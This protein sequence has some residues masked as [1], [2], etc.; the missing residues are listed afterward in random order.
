MD[1]TRQ[2]SSVS[3]SPRLMRAVRYLVGKA[4][5]IALTI[6]AGVFITVLLANQP[7][8]GGLG[9]AT[10]PFEES[11]EAQI[12]RVVRIQL[13]SGGLFWPTTAPSDAEVEALTEELREE[14]G[15]NLPRLPRYLLWTLKA[16]TFDWG[17]LDV[18]RG[19]ATTAL[20]VILEF[21]PNT[22]L[23]IGAAY[24]LVFVLGLPISLYLARNYG[25][26]VDRVFSVLAPVSAVPSWVFAILLI[27]IF[28]FQL[29]WLPFGGKYDFQTPSD[30]LAHALVVAKHMIL[31]VAAI[32]LSLI[33]Q[34]VYTWRTFFIIY[35]EE[36][37]VELARAKGLSSSVLERRYI[38][39]P[40]LPYVVTS[41]LTTLISFWQLSMVQEYVFDW[42]GL[43][44]LYIHEA[45]PNFWGESMDPGELIIVVAIVVIFAYLLG[46]MVF[47]LDFIYVLIDPRILLL[48]ANNARAMRAKT[49]RPGWLNRLKAGRQ[50]GGMEK[51]GRLHTSPRPHRV[52]WRTAVRDLKSTWLE[53]LQRARALSHELRRYP[54]AM[55]GLAVILILLAGSIY[56]VMALP[57]AEIGEDY[58]Q[59]RL[60]GRN[61]APRTAKPAWVNAFSATPLLSALI[62][63]EKSDGTQ[64]S[65]QT[66][67]NGWIQKT[68]AFTFDYAYREI[69]SEVFLYFDSY[70]DE[71][72][73]FVSMVWTYPDGRTLDLRGTA[74]NGGSSYDFE[75]NIRTNQLLNE[76]PAWKDW[77]VSTGQYR[78]PA[79][80]LLF[81][82]PGSSQPVPQRGKY[83][84]TLT[85][86]LF[87]ESSD[88]QPQLV[89]LGQVYGLAGTDHARR[90]LV[91]PLFWG[92]P[93]ALLIG[94]LGTLI[95]TLVAMLLPAIGVWFG[96]WADHI[97]QRLTEINMVL[98]S[99]SVAVLV[100][101]VFSWNIWIILGIV[102]TIN[103][104]G[105]PVKTIRSAL[106]QAKE[107]P[108]IE[109][110]RAYGASDLRII[111]QYLVPRVLPVLIPLV[112]SQ[113]PSFI[114]WEATLGFFNI[115]S[116]YP[117]WGR[118]IYEGLSRGA[119]YGSPFWVLQ[120]I[121]LLLLTGLAFA[122]LGQA[123]ERI[124]NPRVIT[125][126]PVEERRPTSQSRTYVRR[127]YLSRKVVASLM[128]ALI[129]MALFAPV[130]QGKTLASVFISY[131]DEIRTT[132]SL[133]KRPVATTTSAFPVSASLPTEGPVTS[134]D[135]ART[136]QPLSSPTAAPLTATPA[137]GVACIPRSA[138]EDAR[139]IEIVD[140]NTIKVLIN[141]L[142]YVVRYIGVT[143][144]QDHQNAFQAYLENSEL[145]YHKNVRL[146]ADHVE[147]DP[148]G[149]LL[150]YVLV[151]EMFVNQ[152]LLEHG[153]GMAVDIPD[154]AACAEIF[155]DAEQAAREG[156]RGLWAE[157]TPVPTPR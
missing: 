116:V 14:A 17:K 157:A 72:V 98:P 152:Q 64:V 107:A 42:P 153:H 63:D 105:S 127:T 112:V 45:L 119:L 147:K 55:F 27:A 150:R 52:S 137:S 30:P 3:S 151:G 40:A 101:V 87:E 140:G 109:T 24:L 91:V 93:F 110:A 54:S 61:R 106:L 51:E 100:S 11:L 53:N 37:Y 90:D 2:P 102:V 81:A 97:V 123:L 15:L 121:F 114:F 69:P 29:R 16:L 33:F 38:L 138:A 68:V 143:V 12:Q 18:G 145:V 129:A 71:K 28:A 78:T 34:L 6:F 95:T 156:A 125:D 117:S 26:R 82:E 136:L 144:P 74:A 56:A 59:E 86:V 4:L 133:I 142:V 104:L 94:L 35:S 1:T 111:G 132:E 146:I 21:L 89:V 124:L 113:V 10:S 48:P 73:P 128:T 131:F 50:T 92:M 80:T 60:T 47:L 130:V 43:G 99:L 88:F 57:Y 75:T 126:I 5:T 135:L 13:Y 76:H 155:K 148:S 108:Y 23:L 32:V 115:K 70:S 49:R 44:W 154:G 58:G 46:A 85:G 36:D 41:F 19:E 67:E 120:P 20:G 25:N 96:G 149:R 22:L 77:F 8:R 83:Q 141:D 103:A 134:T 122:M 118:I 79:F 62:L 139:V 39:R 31:P 9:P 65:T 84:L 66:L 7:T